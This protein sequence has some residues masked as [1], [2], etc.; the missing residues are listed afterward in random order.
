[1]STKTEKNGGSVVLGIYTEFASRIERYNS[2]SEHGKRYRL[3]STARHIL[4]PNRRLEVCNR[5]MVQ[6]EEWVKIKHSPSTGKAKYGGLMQCGNAWICPVCSG[7]ICNTRKNELHVAVVAALQLNLKPVLITYTLRHNLNDR[8]AALVND[9]LAA[10]RSLTGWRAYRE[11]KSTYKM[12]GYIRALEVTYKTGWHPHFHVMAFFDADVLADPLSIPKIENAL[13]KEWLV[14]L[15]KQGRDAVKGIGVDVKAGDFFVAE[16]IAK[17]GH[18]PKERTW[19]IESEMTQAAA[20]KSR[21]EAGTSPFGF[22]ED[23]LIT[24]DPESVELFAEYAA[25]MKGRSLLQWS[26]G[27]AEFLGVDLVDDVAAL[28][29]TAPDFVEIVKMSLSMWQAILETGSRAAVL[30]NTEQNNGNA[31][32]V[33]S[34]LQAI[35]DRVRDE[36]I[37]PEEEYTG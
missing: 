9:L 35:Y 16:Y 28:D 26:R 22:L 12:A 8:L 31:E 29:M 6:G 7:R 21:G 14:A 15:K 27:F 25:A 18:L 5:V 10:Y 30:D 3:Q 17:F 37:D 11:V 19:T 4:H 33:M 13:M 1:M 32:A 36:K 23:F 2:L 24:G 20:K 34:F